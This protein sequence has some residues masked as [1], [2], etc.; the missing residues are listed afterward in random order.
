MS[1]RNWRR[2]DIA[3]ATGL[4]AAL[5]LGACGGAPHGDAPV[6]PGGVDTSPA[7]VIQFPEGF[8]NVAV[9]CDGPNRVYSSSR[10]SSSDAVAGSVAVVPNDPRCKTTQ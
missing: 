1:P 8:R 7:T 3:L 2:T 5:A 4:L 10:G 9:K 6:E